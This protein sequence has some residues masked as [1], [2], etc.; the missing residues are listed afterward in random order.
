MGVEGGGDGGG[1]QGRVDAVEALQQQDDA[2]VA[3]GFDRFADG[4]AVFGEAPPGGA[5]GGGGG[6]GGEGLVGA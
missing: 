5:G 4:D 1:H 2:L 3:R 6:Q